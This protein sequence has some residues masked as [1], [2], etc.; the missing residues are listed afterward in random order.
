MYYITNEGIGLT[1]AYKWSD[2]KTL[3]ETGLTSQQLVKSKQDLQEANL[4]YFLNNWVVI[5][6][7][8]EKTNFDKGKMTS[9]AYKREFDLLPD[10]IREMLIGYSY[11]IDRVSIPIEIRNKKSEIRNKEK[12]GVGEKTFSKIEDL[13]EEQIRDIAKE[14]QVPEAFVISKIDDLKNYCEST[15]KKYKNYRSTLKQWVKRDAIGIRKEQND[16]SKIA[17]IVE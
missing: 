9:V 13:D 2:S 12:G 16:R 1:G 15:G 8:N 14:Y 6:E 11:P 5:P 3:F 17:F 7:T 4:V 10:E